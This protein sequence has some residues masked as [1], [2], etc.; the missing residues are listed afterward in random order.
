MLFPRKRASRTARMHVPSAR[1]LRPTVP[2]MLELDHH[3]RTQE[4]PPAMH[5]FLLEEGEAEAETAGSI[6]WWAAKASNTLA[7]GM[8]GPYLKAIERVFPSRK[9]Q[10]RLY[11]L[12]A[13]LLASWVDDLERDDMQA[14]VELWNYTPSAQLAFAAELGLRRELTES[15]GHKLDATEDAVEAARTYWD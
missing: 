14:T 12:G 11:M 8:Q 15:T 4:M 3:R 6:N 1:S 5:V 10:A 2:D 13:M 7:I 9:A